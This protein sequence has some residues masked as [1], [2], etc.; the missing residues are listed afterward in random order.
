M[1]KLTVLMVPM[2]KKIFVSKQ[3][4]QRM[5]FDVAMV[6]VYQKVFV[7]LE[8]VDVQMVQMKMSC[9]VE[10]TIMFI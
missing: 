3:L 1:E 4:V 7:A 8:P 6:H 10:L 2:K 5:H 9:F